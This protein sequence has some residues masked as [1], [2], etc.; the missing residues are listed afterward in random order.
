MHRRWML[1]LPLMVIALGSCVSDPT[2]TPIPSNAT[3]LYWSLR[4]NHRAVTLSMVAPYD[5]IRLIATPLTIH[6]TPIKNLPTATFTSLDL[7]HVRVDSTGFVQAVGTGQQIGIVATLTVG[8]D[9]HSDTV[10]LNITDTASAPKLTTFSIHPIPPDS[11]KTSLDRAYT[12]TARALDASGDS[13]PGLAVDFETSDSTVATIDRT[14][15]FMFGH[16]PAHCKIIATTTSY[17]VTKSDTLP[18]TVGNAVLQQIQISPQTDANGHTVGAFVP[19]QFALG[20]V[21]R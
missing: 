14:S 19:N 5:T 1:R 8:D 6:A 20:P 13:I 12:V 9:S 18:F 15:G 4:L 21:E 16:R 3:T 11:A 2:A 17:G 7:E 10:L